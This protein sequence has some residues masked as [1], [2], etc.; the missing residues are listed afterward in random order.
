MVSKDDHKLIIWPSYFDKKLSRSEGRKVPIKFSLEKPDIEK[1][2]KIAKNLG[3]SPEMEKN[4]SH[5]NR[6]FEKEGRIIIDK[7]DKK[8]KII[9]QIS[10]SL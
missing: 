7:T 10:K 4:A 5:P 8:R 9:N 1:I 2:A 6:P 3:L